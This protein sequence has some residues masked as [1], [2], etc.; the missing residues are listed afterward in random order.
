MIC[1]ECT[2]SGACDP[3]DGYGTLPD[4][5]PNAGDGTSCPLCTGDGICADC[6]GTGTTDQ[7]DTDTNDDT[8]A[9]ALWKA[10]A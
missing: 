8:G 9:A 3:C 4:S 6:G 2:G 1:T 5:S 10:S 7:H